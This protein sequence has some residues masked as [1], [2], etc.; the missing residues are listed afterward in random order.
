MSNVG[1]CTALWIL[2]ILLILTGSPLPKVDIFSTNSNVV[3]SVSVLD[4]TEKSTG[5]W[6]AV[7]NFNL[8]TFSELFA[9]TTKS[10][11]ILPPAKLLIALKA[12]SISSKFRDLTNPWLSNA[13]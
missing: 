2:I 9:K 1:L 3:P 10:L 6:V 8:V 4:D 13:I 11:V 5:S 12:S 7:I